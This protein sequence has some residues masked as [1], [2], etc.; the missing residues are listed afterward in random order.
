[1]PAAI[2]VFVIFYLFF[3]RPAGRRPNKKPTTFFRAVG[4]CRDCFYLLPTSRHGAVADYYDDIQPY[5]RLPQN[6]HHLP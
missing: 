6:V 3:C 2:L 1:L 4:F 5:Q